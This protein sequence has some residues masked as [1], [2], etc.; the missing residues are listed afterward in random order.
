MLALSTYMLDHMQT[1][2]LLF[3]IFFIASPI[4]NYG[5]YEK[6]EFSILYKN[7]IQVRKKTIEI[8]ND[9]KAVYQAPLYFSVAQ[10]LPK[11][12]LKLLV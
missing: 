4:Q 8:F 5:K 9:L 3:M 12:T 11:T 7:S 6:R 2:Y 1:F 10:G